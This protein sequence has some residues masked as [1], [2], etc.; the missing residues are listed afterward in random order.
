V[1][2][3]RAVSPALHDAVVATFQAAGVALNVRHEASSLHACLG[4]VGAGLGVSVLPESPSAPKTVLLRT[5]EPA[6]LTL[7]FVAAYREDLSAQAVQAFLRTART[8]LRTP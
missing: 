3:A 2:F 1:L 5:I 8:A 7:D 6:P 4:L